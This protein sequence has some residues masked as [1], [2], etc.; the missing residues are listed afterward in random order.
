MKMFRQNW[1]SSKVNNKKIEKTQKFIES[2]S[3]DTF[4]FSGFFPPQSEED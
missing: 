4:E 2:S 1:H 3:H